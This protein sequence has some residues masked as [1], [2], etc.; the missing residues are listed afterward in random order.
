MFSHFWESRALSH[1]SYLEEKHHHSDCSSLPFSSS[2]FIC[3][4]WCHV[5]WDIPLVS[6]PSCVP[7]Q[8]LVDPSLLAGGV[9]W[10]AKALTLCQ[11][12]SEIKW[13]QTLFSTNS[14]H[15]HSPI[16]AAM[17]KMSCMSS[18]ALPVCE[19]QESAGCQIQPCCCLMPLGLVCGAAAHGGCQETR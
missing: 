16:Q 13:Y 15:K 3:W 6:C 12:C 9:L 14:K 2:S 5:L 10:G 19:L 1:L 17:K 11:P 18:E 4:A 8:P 7:F